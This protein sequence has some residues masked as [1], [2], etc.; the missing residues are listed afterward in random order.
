MRLTV[1][2]L[3]GEERRVKC[4][5]TT[6]VGDLARCICCELLLLLLLWVVAA[7]A[8]VGCCSVVIVDSFEEF[9]CA[10]ILLCFGLACLCLGS[11]LVCLPRSLPA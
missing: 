5:M 8:A 9:A 2:M 10:L 7:A 11:L 1:C 4:E 3:G 6:L